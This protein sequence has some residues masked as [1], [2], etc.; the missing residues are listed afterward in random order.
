MKSFLYV[1]YVRYVRYVSV[2]L[3]HRVPYVARHVTS[4]TIPR[5]M[6]LPDPSWIVR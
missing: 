4:V 2:L 5:H 1:K 6:A 3:V